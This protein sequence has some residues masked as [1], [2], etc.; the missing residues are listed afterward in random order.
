[1]GIDATTPS[2]LCL[3]KATDLQDRPP[4]RPPNHAGPEMRHND[5]RTH[6]PRALAWPEAQRA[7]RGAW[8]VPSRPR[9]AAV[10]CR[11]LLS[12]TCWCRP[13]PTR[14]GPGPLAGVRVRSKAVRRDRGSGPGQQT[15]HGVTWSLAVAGTTPW[16][17]EGPGQDSLEPGGGS[18]SACGARRQ[19]RVTRRCSRR[20]PGREARSTCGRSQGPA[21]RTLAPGGGRRR[22]PPGM[23]GLRLAVPQVPQGPAKSRSSSRLSSGVSSRARA[24]GALAKEQQGVQDDLAGSTLNS[25]WRPNKSTDLSSALVEQGDEVPAARVQAHRHQLLHGGLLGCPRRGLG[26]VPSAG[27]PSCSRAATTSWG[28]RAGPLDV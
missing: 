6:P 24:G 16:G 27:R 21:A 14:E 4:P 1:M 23:S 10:L 15:L 13:H 3:P 7:S 26:P 19:V 5:G 2:M 8:S 17:M 22:P 28:C 25:N 9:P 12:S 20:P 11:S 18:A